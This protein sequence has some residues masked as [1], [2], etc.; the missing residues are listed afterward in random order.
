MFFRKTKRGDDCFFYLFLR[1]MVQGMKNRVR[2]IHHLIFFRV[3]I[4]D[5]ERRKVMHMV[6]GSVARALSRAE[7]C[8]LFFVAP[9]WMLRWASVKT[10]SQILHGTLII[11]VCTLFMMMI[12]ALRASCYNQK[13]SNA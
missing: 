9:G 6:G 2:E 12:F 8:K 10:E 13:Q 11:Y 5:V 3:C 4:F 7:V 1:V